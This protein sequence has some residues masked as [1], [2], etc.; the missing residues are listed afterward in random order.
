LVPINYR[1]E[2]QRELK[3][4]FPRAKYPTQNMQEKIAI[5]SSIQQDPIKPDA[6][7]T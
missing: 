5:A 2:K 3:E 6:G 4:I 1:E 7:K